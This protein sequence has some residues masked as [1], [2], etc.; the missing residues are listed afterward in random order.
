MKWRFSPTKPVAYVST[1]SAYSLFTQIPVHS[2]AP[3]NESSNNIIYSHLILTSAKQVKYSNPSKCLN[4]LD[5]VLYV[6]CVY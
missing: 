2:R 5:Y 4:I 3:Y 6:G 1:F